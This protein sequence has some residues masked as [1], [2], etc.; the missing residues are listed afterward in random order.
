MDERKIYPKQAEMIEESLQSLMSIACCLSGTR[1]M[2]E[3]MAI[4]E[5]IDRRCMGLLPHGC[6]EFTD[7]TVSQARTWLA[8]CMRIGLEYLEGT[9]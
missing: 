2:A 6:A 4:G 8:Q 3:S 1:S 9:N 7:M 5:N